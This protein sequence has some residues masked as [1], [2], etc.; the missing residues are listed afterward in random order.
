MPVTVNGVAI[1]DAAVR[2]EAERLRPDYL[3]YLEQTHDSLGDPERNAQLL[4]W[5]AENLIEAELLRQAERADPVELPEAAIADTMRQV[6]ASYGGREGFERCMAVAPGNLERLRAEVL[7]GLRAAWFVAR[8][9]ADLPAPTAEEIERAYRADPERFRTPELI[10]ARHIVKNRADAPDDAS[11]LEPLRKARSELDAGADFADV[12]DR[13]SD[14]A[15]N[16][17]DLGT[18]MR[19]QMVESFERVVCAMRPGETSDIFSTEF[20][21]HI[22]QLVDRTPARTLG[23][24]EVRDTLAEMLME[25]KRRMAVERFVDDLK[26]H[27]AIV[28]EP[29]EARP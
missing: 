27:A 19:G 24:D 12:A 15:G 2:R 29:V 8:L 4:E 1:E 10:R 20:G 13:Y 21:W 16:G 14:C 25:E 5:A 26:E 28:R 18:F 11:M 9:T 6:E 23:L 17:G 22:A 3:R 7:D